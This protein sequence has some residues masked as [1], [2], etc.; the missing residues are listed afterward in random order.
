MFGQLGISGPV[1]VQVVLGTAGI[2]LAFLVLLRVLGPRVLAPTSAADVGC[3]I[4]LGAIIGR[5]GL[6]ASPSL[7]SGVICLVT[8]FVLQR[9]VGGGRRGRTRGLLSRGPVALVVDGRVSTAP[10]RR[11]RIDDDELRQLLRLAGVASLD[12][13]RL[14]VLERTGQVS[15]VRGTAP[16]PWLVADVPSPR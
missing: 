11:L 3:V 14:A 12:D 7:A 1:A 8:L 15:V 13:V 10:T 16:E 5:T 9:L 6:L 2:Y 4:A